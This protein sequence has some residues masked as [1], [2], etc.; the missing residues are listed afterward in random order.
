[1]R[2]YLL[3]L[4]FISTA[5][6]KTIAQEVTPLSLEECINYA[7][8][9]NYLVKNAKLDVQI[10]NAQSNQIQAGALPRITGKGEIDDNLNAQQAFL[11]AEFFGGPKGSFQAVTFTPHYAGSAY[12]NGTQTLFD[13][14]LL[15][16]LRAKK[17]ILELSRM[18]GEVTK[19]TIRYNVTRSYYSL[20]IAYRQFSV[21]QNTLGYARHLEHDVNI[22][23]KSGFA[24]KIDVERTSV[25]VNN[26]ANDSLRVANILA[27]SEQMLKYQ[28]GMDITTP[29]V[30][31]D[32]NMAAQET[33]AMS[34]LNEDEDYNRV[35]EYNLLTIGL[36][37]NEF[38]V[39]RYQLAALPTL[40]T[41][42]NVGYNYSSNKFKDLLPGGAGYLF[43][44]IVGLQLNVPIFSGFLR[45]N[46]LREAKLNVEKNKNNIAYV[47]QGLDFQ[48]AAARTILTNNLIQAK[49][50][51]S[52][53]EV[54]K[55]VLDLAQ[56]KYK[57]GVG[58]NIEI[59]QAQT[60]LAQ[61][62]N[63]YFNALLDVITAETDLK[64]ALG[65]LK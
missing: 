55:D 34:L 56:K 15:V 63:N 42:G 14:T 38:N 11:P 7:M 35:P 9:H 24:E 26:L 49:S 32:T 27:T 59:D 36:R 60:A 21:I 45:T 47:K 28:M 10:Q 25:Q 12:I 3:T 48:T 44:S 23:Y 41:F 17:T 64:K 58:S 57:A 46:Q 37:L 54:A 52:N 40:N 43:S 6:A 19:E 50:Q 29:I 33:E 53:L 4:L 2:R 16:A 61:A 18:N 51:K 31:T 5:V 20:A 39:K 30:L 1:M 13:G 62:Q 8:R 65:L 22:T